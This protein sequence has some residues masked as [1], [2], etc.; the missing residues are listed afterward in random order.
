MPGDRMK[1][2]CLQFHAMPHELICLLAR[3]QDEILF[4]KGIMVK[5]PFNLKIFGKTDSVGFQKQIPD[6][7]EITVILSISEALHTAESPNKFFDSNPDCL[8][9]D[10][11]RYDQKNIMESTL[12]GFFESAPAIAFANKAACQLK[13][14]TTSGVVAVNP[15]TGAEANIKNHRYTNEVKVFYEQGGRVSPIAGNAYLKIP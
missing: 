15:F 11:G 9:I 7:G 1:K 3:L 2:I 10:I 13:K 5:R 14:I 12:S 6:A 8:I 4:S